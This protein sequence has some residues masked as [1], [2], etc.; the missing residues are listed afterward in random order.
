MESATDEIFGSS[1]A[2][3]LD[4]ADDDVRDGERPDSKLLDSDLPVSERGDR[5]SGDRLRGNS[6]KGGTRE[7]GLRHGDSPDEIVIPGI[8]LS[9]KDPQPT[10]YD[11]PIPIDRI[12][13]D[14]VKVLRR[15]TRHGHTAFLV[16][17]G[18]RD[19]LLHRRPK[20]FDIAT[21]ARPGEVRH[22]QADISKARARLGYSPLFSVSE[23]MQ[24]V[25][26]WYA[27]RASTIEEPATAVALG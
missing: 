14:A 8:H 16:G 23:G 20:D 27:K 17:G 19:L 1:E 3:V 2:V 11:Q 4:D 24:Q 12:D 6:L 22:S 25:V 5:L 21:S 13:P 15:L 10:I 18:V 9:S 26:A 7:H